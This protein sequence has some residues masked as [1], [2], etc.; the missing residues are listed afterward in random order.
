MLQTANFSEARTNLKSYC[1]DVVNEN[2]TLI[3]TRKDNKNVVMQSLDKY[4]QVTTEMQNLKKELYIQKRLFKAEREI[5]KGEG[6]PAED[7]FADIKAMLT[8]KMAGI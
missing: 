5:E 7:V 3:I 6:R 4:N 8:A 1:D 2:A